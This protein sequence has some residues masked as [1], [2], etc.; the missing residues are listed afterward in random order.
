MV[1]PAEHSDVI[2]GLA[3]N[4]GSASG[5]SVTINAVDGASVERL[6]R[7]NGHVMAKELRRQARNFAPTRS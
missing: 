6:F 1:L 5:M 7:S 2:R 3:Q 4:G